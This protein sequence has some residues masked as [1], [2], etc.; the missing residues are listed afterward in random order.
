GGT[1]AQCFG[2]PVADSDL[3]FAG[4]GGQLGGGRPLF[5]VK[6][7]GS[8]DLTLKPGA[9]SSEGVAW[10][11]PKAGPLMATPLLYER[12][13]YVPE[14]NL[15][16]VSCYDARTGKQVYRERLPQARGFFTS[17]WACRG[18]VFCLD[19]E[20]R[21]FVLQPGPEY[22]LL[23]RNEIGE[24]CWASPALAGG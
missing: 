10:S 15:G 1:N 21:T 23:G 17:P 8:G 19:E 14:Q 18:K 16:V 5:A 20:G 13:L 4:T 6:A 3:L 24:R 2:S 12:H 7:G 9:T 22:K 11:L